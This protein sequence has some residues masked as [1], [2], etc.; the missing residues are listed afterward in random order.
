VTQKPQRPETQTAAERTRQAVTAAYS[1]ILKASRG[2]RNLLIKSCC[3]AL[4]GLSA[5]VLAIIIA[6]ASAP[7]PPPAERPAQVAPPE[8]SRNQQSARAEIKL[9]AIRDLIE[10]TTRKHFGE[11]PD[12]NFGTAPGID[13][14]ELL[15]SA[16]K[17]TAAQNALRQETYALAA[18]LFLEAL[19][20][21]PWSVPA[22]QGLGD[23]YLALNRY[24]EAEKALRVAVLLDGFNQCALNNHGVALF[25]LG[26]LQT[27]RDQFARA[28]LID[29]S[30]T[31]A[32]FNE[33]LTAFELDNDEVA[34]ER[35][36]HY[37]QIAAK[38]VETTRL[39]AF[40]RARSGNPEDAFNL[41]TDALTDFPE[42]DELHIDAAACAALLW[43]TE[44]AQQHLE[45]AIAAGHGGRVRAMLNQPA[46]ELLKKTAAG[47]RL[48]RSLLKKTQHVEE[49]KDLATRILPHATP[50]GACAATSQIPETLLPTEDNPTRHT[51]QAAFEA[52]VDEKPERNKP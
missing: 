44:Q 14:E 47:R 29:S 25:Y 52:L 31:D 7:P 51:M 38:N 26:E 46:F 27:A 45:Q 4:L 16:R 24:E 30:F 20:L 36:Q 34:L 17:T 21:N 22:W 5:V 32:V 33:A 9:N 3:A 49:Q 11:L 8:W 13:L 43:D 50:H 39:E 23:A 28:T 2:R 35:L 10:N 15:D 41:L 19:N 37:G 12:R 6:F 18:S 1:Y 48:A 40:I 42:R